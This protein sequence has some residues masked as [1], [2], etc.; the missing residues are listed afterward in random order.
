MKNYIRIYITMISLALIGLGG[1]VENEGFLVGNVLNGGLDTGGY[2]RFAQA[3][4]TTISVEADIPG[5]SVS[6]PVEDANGNAAS[7]T[8]KVYLPG[9]TV[10]DAVDVMTINEFPGNIEFTINDLAN[11]LEIDVNLVDF[12]QQFHFAGSVT[13]EDGRVY[14]ATPLDFNLAEGATGGGTST[15]LL[16]QTGPN[17]YRNALFFTLTVDCPSFDPTFSVDGIYA[18][19]VDQAFG[20]AGFGIAVEAGPGENELTLKDLFANG[21]DIVVSFNPD[22]TAVVAKQH[23]WTSGNFG[24]VTVEGSGRAFSCVNLVTVDLAHNIS[25]GRTF[26][27]FTFTFQLP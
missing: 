27:T 3:T 15:D 4:P 2:I 13:T 10:V 23:A 18:I 19:L 17:G 9:Q 5:A 14:D 20:Q 8:L 11:V 22:G 7:Y 24:P 1:C 6:F 26:G 16:G 25:D 12:G 21:L